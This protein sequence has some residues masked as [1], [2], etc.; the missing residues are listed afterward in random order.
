MGAQAFFLGGGG[1]HP[2]PMPRLKHLGTGDG[3]VEGDATRTQRLASS[4]WRP[5]SRWWRRGGRRRL[6]GRRRD[7]RCLPAGQ[8]VAGWPGPK[9]PKQRAT[10]GYGPTSIRGAM[11]R[12]RLGWGGATRHPRLPPSRWLVAGWPGPPPA[13]A[14]SPRPVPAGRCGAPAAWPRSLTYD[15]HAVTHADSWPAGGWVAGPDRWA[16]RGRSTPRRPTRQR[17]TCGNGPTSNTISFSGKGGGARVPGASPQTQTF[18]GG[19]GGATCKS[20]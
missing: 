3:W 14:P 7:R 19:G 16:P 1:C 17:S 8:L 15:T 4:M 6:G 9:G 13:S 5:P 11:G 20:E 10:C 2:H 12:K 18:G